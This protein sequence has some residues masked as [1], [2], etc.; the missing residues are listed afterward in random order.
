MQGSLRVSTSFEV[1]V[2]GAA[3]EGGDAVAGDPAP[4]GEEFKADEVG[5]AGEGGGAGV[6]RVAVAGG[7]ERKNLPEVLLGGG[8][9]VERRRRPRGRGRRCLRRKAER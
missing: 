5:I 3:G 9:E 6:G 8:E 1:D 2:A 4:V 7:A